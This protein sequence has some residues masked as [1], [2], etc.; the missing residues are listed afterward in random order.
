ML[1]AAL[2]TA[3][4]CV[5]LPCGDDMEILLLIEG[6]GVGRVAIM[7]EAVVAVAEISVDELED[8]EEELQ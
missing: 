7:L 2:L 3:K 1:D 5:V 4:E 8:M 6:G